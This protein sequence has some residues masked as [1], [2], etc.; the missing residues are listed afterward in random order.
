MNN[1]IETSIVIE[2]IK[3]Q[4]NQFADELAITE[5]LVITLEHEIEALRKA[6][7]EAHE[8]VPHGE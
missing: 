2:R 7:A 4:R 3:E 1:K 6:V 5:A 8:R